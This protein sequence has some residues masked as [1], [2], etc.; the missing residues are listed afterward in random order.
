MSPIE[1]VSPILASAS[2][3][4]GAK[5]AKKCFSCHTFD[6]DGQNKIGPNL[7]NIIGSGIAKKS[8]Y[9][10]SKALA[11]FGGSWSFENLSKFLYKP[12]NYVDGTKMNFAGLKKVE[13]RADLILWLR[14]KSDNPIP[15][16]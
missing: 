6:K 9:A 11:S 16:T 2:I 1:E 8:G 10:Y 4:N 13:D 7:Y 5:I 15:L 3:E 12:K 14:E